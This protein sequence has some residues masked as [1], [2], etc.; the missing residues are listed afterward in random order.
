M[1]PNQGGVRCTWQGRRLGRAI[2]ADERHC[3]RVAMHTGEHRVSYC[4]AG[5]IDTRS[6]SVPVANNAVVTTIGSLGRQ[7]ATHDCGSRKLFVERVAVHVVELA[8]RLR[9]NVGFTI[10]PRQRRARIARDEGCCV[11]PIAAV[12]THL[13]ERQSSERLNTRQEY[14]TRITVVTTGEFVVAQLWLDNVSHVSM[15]SYRDPDR[16]VSAQVRPI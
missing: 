12:D 13:L 4:I 2:V 5:A 14:A 10:E 3:A 15:L 1:Q 8:C 16:C 6:L 9:G 7:L 11:E